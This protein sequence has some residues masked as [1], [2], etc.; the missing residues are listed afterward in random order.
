MRAGPITNMLTIICPQSISVPAYLIVFQFLCEWDL[1][2]SLNDF[3][4]GD[5]PN[6]SPPVLSL[7]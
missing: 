6:P 7:R 5:K 3:L 4:I 2:D 1:T